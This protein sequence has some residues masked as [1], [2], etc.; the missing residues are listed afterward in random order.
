MI[1]FI[2]YNNS[3]AQINNSKVQI[4]SKEELKGNSK[5]TINN[6]NL[7]F[8]ELYS[9]GEEI[10]GFYSKMASDPKTKTKLYDEIV[11]G[12]KVT[13]QLYYQKNRMYSLVYRILNEKNEKIFNCVFDFDEHNNCIANTE[14]LKKNSMSYTNAM[15][16]DSL[17]RLDVGYNRINITE[18]QKQKIIQSTKL[19]LDSL[20]R[21]F[22]EF[23]YSI[24]WK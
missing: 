12:N 22:P 11:N 4:K 14:K 21:H 15:Y 8:D 17:V 2:T 7:S 9:K 16:W 13:L 10:R 20:M 24:N 5:S 23:K 1:C 19:S 18:D 6:P 3:C